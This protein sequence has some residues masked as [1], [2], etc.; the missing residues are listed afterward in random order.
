MATTCSACDTTATTTCTVCRTALC[1]THTHQGQPFISARQLVTATTSTALRAPGMLSDMLFKE[2]ELVPYCTE[3]REELAA[4]R[5]TEQLKV[6][7]GILVILALVIGLPTYL[8]L[9]A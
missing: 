4:K 9:F 8:V 3:C 7:L 6:L 2:L 5:T 1:A